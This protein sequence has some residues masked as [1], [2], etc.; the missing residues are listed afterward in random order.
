MSISVRKN[1]LRRPD[2]APA[3]NILLRPA[4]F[5]L[6]LG[7]CAAIF[8]AYASARSLETSYRLSRA[9]EQ[10]RELREV[11]RRLRVELGNLRSPQRLEQAAQRAAL[12]PP[13]PSQ[14]RELP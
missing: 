4:L 8:Y 10:Q 14:M 9:L 11:G 6:V 7:T 1:N 13:L 12:N 2:K 5:M 3:R